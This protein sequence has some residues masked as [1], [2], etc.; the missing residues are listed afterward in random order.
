M[1]IGH[2]ASFPSNGAALCGDPPSVTGQ[3][4]PG[5]RISCALSPAVILGAGNRSSP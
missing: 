2:R 1:V 4:R 5:Q 3:A